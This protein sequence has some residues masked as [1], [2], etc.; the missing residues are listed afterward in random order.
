LLSQKRTDDATI[1]F[2]EALELFK[3]I[4]KDS[5]AVAEN[6]FSLAECYFDTGDITKAQLYGQ[7]SRRIREDK[8]G[9]AHPKTIECF[10]QLAKLLSSEYQEYKGVVTQPIAKSLQLAISY[11]EK[12]FRY[13]KTKQETATDR[14]SKSGANLLSLTRTII[15]LKMKLFT[16]K[17]QEEC[18]RITQSGLDVSQ[19]RM[20]ETVLKLVNLTPTVYIDDVLRR[21]EE[22]DEHAR[23]EMAAIVMLSTSDKLSFTA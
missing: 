5:E 10:R 21:V 12:V 3:V 6:N 11:Y 8:L 22:R 19:Q 17:E 15:A 14:P 20:K 7:E 2:R 9:Q 18:Q 4:E 1:M 23:Q 13:W 16:S